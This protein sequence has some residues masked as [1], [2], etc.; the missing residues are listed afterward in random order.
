MLPL[1]SNRRYSE[2]LARTREWM[3]GFD[4]THDFNHVVKVCE[5][6]FKILNDI[7]LSYD[8]DIII[9]SAI[10]HDVCDHKYPNSISVEVRDNFIIE[11]LGIEKARKVKLIIDNVSYSKESKGLCDK[12]EDEDTAFYLDVIRDADRL[13]ALGSE[14]LRRCIE[15]TRLRGGKVPEDVVAHC[16]DKLLKLADHYIKTIPGK[17]MA[18]PLHQEIL[19]YVQANS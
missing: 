4:D 12:I 5:N 9:Y 3:S 1:L 8:Q 16:H 14:G 18:A 17:R 15:F 19:A 2:L 10:L 7:H 13:E 11:S 6:A